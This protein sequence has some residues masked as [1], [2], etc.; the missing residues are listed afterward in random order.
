MMLI[1]TGPG[2][3]QMKLKVYSFEKNTEATIII[4]K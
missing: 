3:A 1:K 2:A 4:T